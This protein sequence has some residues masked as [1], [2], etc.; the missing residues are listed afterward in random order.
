MLK[1]NKYQKQ[2]CHVRLKKQKLTVL[3]A[4]LSNHAHYSRVCE[5]SY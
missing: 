1:K 2:H 3:I 5:E 4:K